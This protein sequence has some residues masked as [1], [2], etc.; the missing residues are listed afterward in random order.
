VPLVAK[1][2]EAVA[3]DLPTK[4]WALEVLRD[5]GRFRSVTIGNG[6]G[7]DEAMRPDVAELV[8]TAEIPV[9]VDADAITLLG[10]SARDVV[11]PMTVLTP[12]DGE[13]ARLTGEP[14]RPDRV[15][16]VRAAAID[17]GA[18]LLLKGPATIVASPEGDVLVTVA[19]DARL[20]TLGTGDVLAGVIAALCASGLDP[21]RA[22][23][24]GS[25][26]HGRAAALGWRRGFVASDLL[27]LLPDALDELAPTRLEI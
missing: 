3:V 10:A 8:R 9:V 1:P 23:A 19:G 26:L 21:F 17:L 18:V 15:A 6:L 11:T 5:L 20:A 27:D 13:F 24:A 7:I 22:A 25:F 12:H 4:G 16:H 14:P 2:L